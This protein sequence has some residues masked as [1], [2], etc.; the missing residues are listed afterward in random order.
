MSKLCIQREFCFS[1]GSNL[2]DRLAYLTAGRDGLRDMLRVERIEQSSVY[3]TAPVGVSPEYTGLAFLNAIVIADCSSEAQRCLEICMAIESRS[4]RDRSLGVNSP[5]TLDIDIICAGDLELD[6]ADLQIPHPRWSERAFVLRP[7]AE[8][9]P[10]LVL[11]GQTDSVSK[12]LDDLGQNG[13]VRPLTRE[14]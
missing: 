4:L 9:R 1:L 14:W 13:R 12:L 3:E 10:D 5:R 2:G 7:L 6:S 11:P 8:L